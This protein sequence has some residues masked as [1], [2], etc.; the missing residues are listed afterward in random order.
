MKFDLVWI[1]CRALCNRPALPRARTRRS[2]PSSTNSEELCPNFPLGPWYG[3]YR[4]V[5]MECR[6]SCNNVPVALKFPDVPF[7]H[8]VDRC[9]E[10]IILHS[11]EAIK[12]DLGSLQDRNCT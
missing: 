1:F 10:K 9:N 6:R 2:P 8:P 11:K 12:V 5:G 7:G 3:T 4:T